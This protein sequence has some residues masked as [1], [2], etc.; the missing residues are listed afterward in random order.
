M[1]NKLPSFYQR[2]GPLLRLVS[3]D[4]GRLGAEGSALVNELVGS[5]VPSGA[6]RVFFRLLVAKLL[7]R[8]VDRLV[9]TSEPAGDPASLPTPEGAIVSVPVVLSI[10]STNPA[11]DG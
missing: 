7:L 9:T 10:G 1:F 11:V 4:F 2:L 8:P 3:A 6:I 5:G